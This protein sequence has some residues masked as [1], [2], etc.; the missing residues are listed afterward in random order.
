MVQFFSPNFSQISRCQ[1]GGWSFQWQTNGRSRLVEKQWLLGRGDDISHRTEGK[2][3]YSPHKWA[4]SSFK[5]IHTLFLLL[6][7][8]DP[9]LCSSFRFCPRTCFWHEEVSGCVKAEPYQS[10]HSPS[11]RRPK[12]WSIESDVKMLTPWGLSLW[13]KWHSES[14]LTTYWWSLVTSAASLLCPYH[15]AVL[16]FVFLLHW[17]NI[18]LLKSFEPLCVSYAG[19]LFWHV[20]KCKPIGFVLGFYGLLSTICADN[21]FFTPFFFFCAPH[22]L[23]RTSWS[24]P[25]PNLTNI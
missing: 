1:W 3:N 15:T 23:H 21:F 8:R 11:E 22:H 24:D 6:K 18:E 9:L 14:L 2:W 17:W 10:K 12:P 7:V 16:V 20:W 13:T 25:A 4:I 19:G 5:T